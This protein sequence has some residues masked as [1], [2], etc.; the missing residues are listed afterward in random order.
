MILPE[1]ECPGF[2]KHYVGLVNHDDLSELT[3]QL[4]SY[5]NFIRSIPKEKQLYRYAE[6]KWTIKEIVGHNTDTERIKATAAFRI[7]RNDKA[8]LPGFDEDEYVLAT[9][10]NAREMEDLLEEFI[11][12]RKSTIALF[13]SLSEEELKR[14]GTASNK[15]VSARTLFYFLVGHIIHHEIVLKERY[16][17]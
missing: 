4:E 2:Y 12:V 15:N 5:V 9:N 16:L 8:S 6:K 3:G 1:N 11:M 17:I 10:F 7:A 13:Q 14:I